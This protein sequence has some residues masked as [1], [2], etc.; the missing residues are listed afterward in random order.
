M[1]RPKKTTVTE[2]KVSLRE[3]L[4]QK[5]VEETKKRSELMKKIIAV[6]KNLTV[7][8]FNNTTGTAII[9][10]PSTKIIYRL[11]GYGATEL[12]PYE[13]FRHLVAQNKRMLTNYYIVPLGL[14]GCEDEGI[15]LSDIFEALKVDGLYEEDIIDDTNINF[16]IQ[17]TTPEQFKKLLGEYSKEYVDRI[18]ER[19]LELSKQGEFNDSRKRNLLKKLYKNSE[20]VFEQA[21]ELIDSEDDDI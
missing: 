14:Y 4:K 8:I 11:Q 9:K 6:S 2:E 19:A 1:A 21:D 12:I 3:Q 13:T 18:I 5:K 20:D 17:D 10:D 16:I 15:I 7:E